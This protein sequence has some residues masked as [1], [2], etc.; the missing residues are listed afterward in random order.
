MN[1][2]IKS[3]KINDMFVLDCDFENK[4]GRP[5]GFRIHN[6]NGETFE[7]QDYKYERFTQC[8][9]DKEPNPSIVTK[10]AIPDS[11]LQQGNSIERIYSKTN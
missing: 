6:I 9:S 10:T 5:L 7:I 4:I 2:I 1:K 3:E 11:F 8:F